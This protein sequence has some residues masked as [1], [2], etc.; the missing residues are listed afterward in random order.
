MKVNELMEILKEVNGDLDINISIE[1][2]R[3]L[4]G[5]NESIE[6]SYDDNGVYINGEEDYYD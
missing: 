5:S 6:V 1:R 3:G 4:S 2:N